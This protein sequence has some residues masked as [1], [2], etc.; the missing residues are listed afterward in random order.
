MNIFSTL[1]NSIDRISKRINQLR[2]CK[3]SR[4]VKE[5]GDENFRGILNKTSKV[6]ERK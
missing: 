6:T 2:G 4:K 3:L 1:P 5:N